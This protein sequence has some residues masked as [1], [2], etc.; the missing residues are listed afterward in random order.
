MSMRF[1]AQK[2]TLCEVLR[3][4]NDALQG[5]PAHQEVLPKL[6]EAEQMAKRMAKALYK[7]SR[8]FDRDWWDANPGYAEKLERRMNENYIS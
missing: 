3:E 6:R 5:N 2:R 8:E 4:I 1:V 7:H